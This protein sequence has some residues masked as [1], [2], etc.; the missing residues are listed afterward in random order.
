MCTCFPGGCK[1]PDWH[2]ASVG[3]QHVWD[4]LMAFTDGFRTHPRLLLYLLMYL[5]S[6]TEAIV[7]VSKSQSPLRAAGVF[8]Y[9]SLHSFLLASS[10]PLPSFLL[11]GVCVFCASNVIILVRQASWQ[12]L[13]VLVP[14]SLRHCVGPWSEP[15]RGKATISLSLITYFTLHAG[16]DRKVLQQPRGIAV[17]CQAAGKRRSEEVS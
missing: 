7:I 13:N 9:L 17:P 16:W 14:A 5:C 12:A 15:R 4:T 10:V 11:V 6:T 8:S 3:K 1:S 2:V